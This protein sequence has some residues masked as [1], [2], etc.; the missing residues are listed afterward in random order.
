MK[1]ISEQIAMNILG[2][3]LAY[4]KGSKSELNDIAGQVFDD[5]DLKELLKFDNCYSE[6]SW[7]SNLKRLLS[8][9]ALSERERLAVIGN[10]ESPIMRMH[11]VLHLLNPVHDLNFAYEAV[12]SLKDIKCSRVSDTRALG[13]RYI[14]K[15]YAEHGDLENFKVLLKKCEPAKERHFIE[16]CKNSLLENLIGS[17]SKEEIIKLCG[18]K[19]F[20]SRYLYSG[21]KPLAQ[22]TAFWEFK[23]ELDEIR[24]VL[25]LYQ[26]EQLL[27]DSYISHYKGDPE[28]EA[29]NVMFDLISEIDAKTKRGDFRLRDWLFTD[30]GRVTNKQMLV[31]CKKAI[32]HPLLK[33]ELVDHEKALK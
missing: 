20:S 30:L 4:S 7:N 9:S 17:P 8:E 2:M 33:G 3:N 29:F 13:F 21:L 5:Y 27:T 31:K 26:Y 24:N 6:L 11:Q 32:K 19:E 16:T 22:R 25:E 23:Q 18:T 1:D 14:L 10:I 12:E 15:Y 28:E